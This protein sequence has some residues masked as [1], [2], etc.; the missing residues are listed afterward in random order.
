MRASVH[1]RYILTRIIFRLTIFLTIQVTP[2]RSRK[3]QRKPETWKRNILKNKRLIGEEYMT[4]KGI[5]KPKKTCKEYVHTCRYKCKLFT[6]EERQRLFTKLQELPSYDMKTNFLASCIQKKAPQRTK[7]D[8]RNK[9]YST[10]ITLLGRR[11]C[12]DFFL[13]TFDITDSRFKVVCKKIDSDGF[14]A[15]DKRGR[16]QPKNK[17][18]PESKH[19]VITHIQSFPRYKSHYSRSQ[20]PNTSYLSPDLNV[21]KMYNLYTEMCQEQNKIPVKESYYRNI[22]NGEFNMRFH[23]PHS[24]TC[25]ICDKLNN[26]IKNMPLDAAAGSSS[27]TGNSRLELELHQ[28]RAQNA[29]EAKNI[30]AANSKT[31]NDT[32]V[33]C[34]DLQK[35]LPTPL[36]TTNKVYYLR[37]LWTYNLCI[38]D[39]TNGK[40]HMYV[41]NESVASRG[42]KEIG[43]C[44]LKVRYNVYFT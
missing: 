25:N 28:R 24:D 11:V 12:R 17:M 13:K 2:K 30:D 36:L 15:T 8:C 34:F 38:H 43:S 14:V 37:Q 27:G 5:V 44:L 23:H 41:W 16:H 22:F 31:V 33:I 3:R 42:S 19:L 35:T 9:G 20:N 18:P 21:R 29:V 1:G 7:V 4:N 40:P 32:V 26:T 6:E 39:L 10:I